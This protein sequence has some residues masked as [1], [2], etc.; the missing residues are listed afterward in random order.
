MP[1]STRV[2]ELLGSLSLATDL[3]DGFALEKS[4]RT[5]VIA[6]RLAAAA[7][8]SAED[9]RLTFWATLLRF[10]GCTAFAHEEGAHFSAGEDIALRRTLAYVDFGRPSMFVKSALRDIAAHAPI[11]ERVKALGK[12]V[13]TDAPAEHAHAQCEAG[14]HFARQ[15]GMPEI[16]RL[17][18]LRTARFDHK[19]PIQKR[20][21]ELPLPARLADVADVLELFSWSFGV[22]AALAELEARSGGELDPALVS[23]ARKSASDLLVGVF[24]PS[25]WDTFLAAEPTPLAVASDAAAVGRMLEAFSGFPDLASAFT[26]S[27]STRVAELAA[28]ATRHLGL[29][30]EEAELARQSGYVHDLGRVAVPNGIWE[31]RGALTPYERERVRQ[32]SQQTE[33]ILRLA[34]SLSQLAEIASATHERGGGRGY[35]RRLTLEHLPAIARVVAA[36]DV[37]VALRS[38]R[39]HRAALTKDS[40]ERTLLD[41]AETGALD[42]A[43]ARAVL[44]A[45]GHTK[46][47]RSAWPRGLT[48][49]EVE[50]IRLVAVGR[51]NKEIGALLSVSPRTAQK[52]VMNVYDKVGVES[53]AGLA[54]FAMENRLLDD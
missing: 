29:G 11:A 2:A 35:H 12:L 26:L 4:L 7:G 44:A 49:R 13:L 3:A 1:P 6:T 17:V 54:L 41:E 47:K 40:A 19:G 37:Y 18:G 38:N 28:D 10:L 39:P 15:L 36:A 5:T 20:D 52:H 48:E 43:A 16:A 22:D 25:I 24:G 31:K 27:H 53:R 23:A 30:A 9:A 46:P 34:P 14:A 45:A 51:T 50:V 33:T 42:R 8:A 21:V 32:H